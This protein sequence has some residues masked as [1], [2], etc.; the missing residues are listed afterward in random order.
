MYFKNCLLK[1]NENCL[2][3]KE[4]CQR[5]QLGTTQPVGKCLTSGDLVRG[6]GTDPLRHEA[7]SYLGTSFLSVKGAIMAD[8]YLT[9][10]Q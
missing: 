5:P 8:L 1:S 4:T 7:F 10:R 2:K 3:W 6:L 9:A